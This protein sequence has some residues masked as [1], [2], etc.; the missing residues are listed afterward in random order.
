MSRY[1]G[2][3]DSKATLEA[4]EHWKQNALL[5]DGSIFSEKLLWKL[6]HLE[7]LD[8]YFIQQPDDSERS[9]FEKLADQLTPTLPEVKQL[10]AEL[11][12]VKFLVSA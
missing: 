5:A 7:A 1:C 2:D 3:R 8:R 11:L 9:F 6:E 10:A 12:W 4:A